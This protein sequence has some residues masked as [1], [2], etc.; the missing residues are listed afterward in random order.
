[1]RFFLQGKAPKK[2]H[3][4][5]AETLEE[6][7]P[8]YTT[9]K[10]WMAQYKHGDFSACGAHHRGRPKTGTSQRLLIKFTS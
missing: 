5:L 7:A 1:V 3:A 6:H 9:V 2:I 8:L 4:I 10:H